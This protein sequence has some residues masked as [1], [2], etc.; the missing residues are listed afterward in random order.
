[1]IGPTATGK[2]D[3]AI[4][5]AESLG[6]EIVNADSVQVFQ[7]VNIGTAKPTATERSRVPHRL[8]DIVSEGNDFTA[9]RY[10][11]RARQ[12]I[13]DHELK[14]PNK[15]LFFVGGSGFYL[16]AL[17][18]GMF[19]VDP[20]SEDIINEIKL[21]ESLC[22][23]SGLFDWLKALDFQ[24]S[25][26][27]SENDHYRVRR[28]LEMI[29]THDKSMSEIKKEF[30]LKQE[31]VSLKNP[32]LKIG[33]DRDRKELK[34]RVE[35]RI[36]KMIDQGLELEV[37]NLLLKGLE[38]WSPMKSVGYIE[39]VHYIKGQLTQE[40]WVQKMVQNT[41]RLA[42]KQRTWFRRDPD[43]RWIRKII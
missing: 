37:E 30:E 16:Q 25:N 7:S 28:G 15:P 14:S 5:M 40:E 12:C 38:K 39:T 34:K 18:K 23:P 6:G 9:G 32:I 27:I 8:F 22:G 2:T 29:L 4:E 19:E 11:E 1:M 24:Y 21:K 43:I 31:K 17:E 3:L 35:K 13:K 33:L 20:P 36:Y 26:Q 41:M 10:F 42:K